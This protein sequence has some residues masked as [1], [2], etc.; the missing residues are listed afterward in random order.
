MI[1]A[2]AQPMKFAIAFDRI[3]QG[4]NR[5]PRVRIDRRLCDHQ[6]SGFLCL[7]IACQSSDIQCRR[8]TV[9][10][11]DAWPNVEKSSMPAAIFAGGKIV[12]VAGMPVCGRGDQRI[13]ASTVVID[14]GHDAVVTVFEAHISGIDLR[15]RCQRSIEEIPALL[16]AKETGIIS[17]GGCKKPERTGNRLDEVFRILDAGLICPGDVFT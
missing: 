15:G 14:P 13:G 16:S 9:S 7:R 12:D 8:S 4:N 6:R 17:C 2:L 10:A 11:N 3:S 1:L 5:E